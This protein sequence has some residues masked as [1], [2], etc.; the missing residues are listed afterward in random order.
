MNKLLIL[1]LLLLASCGT[2]KPGNECREIERERR[3]FKSLGCVE[4]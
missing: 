4:F 3:V 2:I 1:A